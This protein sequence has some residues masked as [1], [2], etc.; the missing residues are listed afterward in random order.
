MSGDRTGRYLHKTF[1]ARNTLQ[2]DGFI[3][4]S[5]LVIA[6]N[7]LFLTNKNDDVKNLPSEPV[8]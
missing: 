5:K 6:T 1:G 8:V 4:F 2:V 3:H 7:F